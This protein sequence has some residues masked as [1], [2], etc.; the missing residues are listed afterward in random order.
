MNNTSFYKVNFFTDKI[1]LHIDQNNNGIT[2]SGRT[3][4]KFYYSHP[5]NYI[6]TAK[7]P[8]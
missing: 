1:F 4:N 2:F 3:F 5:D 8:F 7:Q 6:L